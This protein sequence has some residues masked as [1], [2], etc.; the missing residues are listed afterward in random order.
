MEIS[1]DFDVFKEITARRTSESVTENDVLRGVFGLPP[2]SRNVRNGVGDGQGGTPFVTG[3]VKF[4]A[5]TEFRVEYLGKE[6]LGSVREGALVLDSTGQAY[7]S[8]SGAALAVTGGI[9]VNGWRFWS[10]RKPGQPDWKKVE[11]LR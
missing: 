7:K 9:Q 8:L 1:V 10:C 4:P 3:N 11:R 5:G 2:V 6:Y